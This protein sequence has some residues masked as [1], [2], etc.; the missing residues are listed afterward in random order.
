MVRLHGVVRLH[1]QHTT[2][3]PL[4]A[5]YLELAGVGDW[6]SH[7]AT[8]SR[9]RTS[10]AP[11]TAADATYPRCCSPTNRHRCSKRATLA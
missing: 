9:S 6:T 2:I 11:S 7:P 1:N 5:P 4:D 3:G 8:R 10:R